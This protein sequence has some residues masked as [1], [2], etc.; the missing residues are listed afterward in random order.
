MAA[1]P[2]TIVRRPASGCQ[3]EEGAAGRSGRFNG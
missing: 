1:L 2:V 3:G